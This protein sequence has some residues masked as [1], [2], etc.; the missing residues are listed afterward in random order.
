MASLLSLIEN[1]TLVFTRKTAQT[2]VDPETGNRIYGEQ[3]FVVAGTLDQKANAPRDV[4]RRQTANS[5]AVW[6][7]GA[8]TE[9][10]ILPDWIPKNAMALATIS[11]KSGKLYL[12]PKVQQGAILAFDM[13]E[14]TGQEIQGWFELD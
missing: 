12:V 11:G 3:A 10:E 2:G 14:L 5:P 7:E 13:L 8:C 9:P 4:E 1:S 6:V